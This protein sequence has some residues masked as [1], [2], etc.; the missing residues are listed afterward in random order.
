MES[1]SIPETMPPKPRNDVLPRLLLLLVLD[2]LAISLSPFTS[3]I[4]LKKFIF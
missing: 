4:T 2:I 1:R 3:Q